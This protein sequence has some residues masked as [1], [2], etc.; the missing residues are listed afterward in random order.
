M[1]LPII[2][3]NENETITVTR[4]LPGLGD[5][6]VQRGQQVRAMDVVARMRSPSRYTAINVAKQLRKLNLDM[7]EVMLKKVG[8]VVNAGEMIATHKSGFLQRSVYA[9]AKGKIVSI[10]QSWVLMETE[11]KVTQLQAFIDGT[12]SRVIANRGVVIKATGGIVQATCGFGGEAHGLLKRIVDQPTDYLSPDE[13]D[14]H[15]QNTILVAGQSIDE[16][17]LR[18][19][20]THQV[21]GV[22]VGSI[23]AAVLALADTLN[24]V[25]V[26]TEG[27]GD[28]SMSNYTFNLLTHFSGQEV[29]IRGVTPSLEAPD[30]HGVKIYQPPIILAPAGKQKASR[31]TDEDNSAIKGELQVGSRVRVARGE[32]V[33]VISTIEAFPESPQPMLSGIVAPGAFLT[34]NQTLQYIPLANLVQ[35]Y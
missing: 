7:S 28:I 8:N 6:K 25:V 34:I 12:V 3:I 19:A 5:V 4:L 30:A 1:Q 32:Y 2:T 29:S 24:L 35:V 18:E 14:A 21:R 33:G 9:P 31:A 16:D 22:I 27:F 17:T 26:A 15:A 10:G 23:D 13:I 20:A 11:R